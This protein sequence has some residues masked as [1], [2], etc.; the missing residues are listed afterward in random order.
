MHMLNEWDAIDMMD[1]PDFKSNGLSTEFETSSW[2]VY[3]SF[4]HHIGSALSLSFFEDSSKD[5]NS[6]L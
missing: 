6:Q 5:C 2:S 4:I 3:R 1:V